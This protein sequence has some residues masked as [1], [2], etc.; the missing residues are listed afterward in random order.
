M[1]LVSPVK[2]SDEEKLDI[3]QRPIPAVA[4]PG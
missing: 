3:L 2:L 4:L 1:A